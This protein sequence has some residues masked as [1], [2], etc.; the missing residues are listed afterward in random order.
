ME[1]E[2]LLT[3][4]NE[5]KAVRLF[6]GRLKNIFNDRLILLKLYGSAVRGERSDESDI[7]I[8]VLIDK[9]RWPEKRGVWD[10]ATK[11]NIKCD[12]MLSPLVMTPEEF[13]E[14]RDRERRIALDIDREGVEI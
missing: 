13:R 6:A 7:D 8:L 11:I 9:L 4:K 10:E 3:R 12:A 5:Q 2:S 1:K 14:L